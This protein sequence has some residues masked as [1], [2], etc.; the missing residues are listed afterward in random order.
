MITSETNRR[1]IIAAAICMTAVIVPARLDAQQYLIKF[2][3]LASEGTTW[4]NV[5]K[6]YDQAIRKE[7]GGR[8]GFKIYPN[9]VQGDELD[10]LRKIKLGQLQSGGITGNGM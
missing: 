5:M 2:A 8:M 7:S 1:L 4:L 9:A 3:T 6:E 10:V